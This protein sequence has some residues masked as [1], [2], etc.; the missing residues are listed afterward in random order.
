M[1]KELTDRQK[2]A[3]NAEGSVIVYAAAG[4]GKTAVLTE[5][6]IRILTDEEHPVDADRLLTVTFTNA[7]AA[8][9]EKIARANEAVQ[10]Q[11]EGKTVVKVICVPKRIVNLVVK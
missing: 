1:G 2:L 4:S 6:V 7:A 10:K 5:R 11:I 9:M 8:E 3:V